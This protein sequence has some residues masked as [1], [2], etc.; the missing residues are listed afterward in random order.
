MSQPLVFLGA[1]TA[2][3]EVAPLIAAVNRAGSSSYRVEAFLDDNE[4]LHGTSHAGI[5]VAGPLAMAKDYRDAQFVFAIGSHRTRLLRE[6]I[7]ERI[8][9]P[10]DRFA[11]LIDPRA[12]IHDRVAIGPGSIIHAGVVIGADC[13]IGP[14]T[15]VT[16]NSVIGP[17]SSVG[18]C[19]MMT[20]MVTALTGVRI[21]ASAYIGAASCIGEG[22]TIGAGAM[23]GM[24][25]VI[26]R[27]ID[28]GAYVL[29]NPA[30]VLYTNEVPANVLRAD[31][32]Q[33]S[34]TSTSNLR[35]VQ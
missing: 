10:D 11:T 3:H 16:F 12:I 25:S 34:V 22:V 24:A 35:A 17:R 7:L 14:F 6:S 15:I 23:V 30:R 13:V 5:P 20:S 31:A 4:A 26:S 18:R 27:D 21:G 1:A 2:Y 32:E 33:A 19:A 9:L 8:G 29:G 28:A